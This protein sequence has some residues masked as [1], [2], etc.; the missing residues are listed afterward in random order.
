M[1]SASDEL[2][3]KFP[4]SDQEARE[5]L[6]ENFD[7]DRGVITPKIEGYSPTEREWDAVDY[8][9]GEWDYAYEA[10]KKANPA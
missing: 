9:C 10:K 7:N 1:P 6:K 5:V 4:G 3:A 8:L 2:R